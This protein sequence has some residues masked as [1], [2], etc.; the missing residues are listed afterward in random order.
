MT[1]VTSGKS[2]RKINW[3]RPQASTQIK[4]RSHYGTLLKLQHHSASGVVAAIPVLANRIA[5][6]LVNNAIRVGSS[7][8]L[9]E[10]VKRESED[11]EGSSNLN[12]SMLN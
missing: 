12:L 10:P 9:L 1:G 5:Q 2:S 11:M 4:Q 6:H 7:I 3:Q 8:I